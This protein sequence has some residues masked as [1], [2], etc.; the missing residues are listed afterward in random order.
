MR[1]IH[2]H[3]DHGGYGVSAYGEGLC[4][5][6]LSSVS[7]RSKA[8][9]M[10]ALPVACSTYVAAMLPAQRGIR[11]IFGNLAAE[12]S[13]T[14]GPKIRTE[15]SCPIDIE[16]SAS[17][18]GVRDRRRWW[19]RSNLRVAGPRLKNHGTVNTSEA[20]CQ[21]VPTHSLKLTPSGSV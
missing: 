5:V 6:E 13:M 14:P 3:M 7:A 11:Q 15:S 4:V 1:V 2:L 16:S 21:Q 17:L 18:S 8:F 20:N 12:H 19:M 10:A 9:G